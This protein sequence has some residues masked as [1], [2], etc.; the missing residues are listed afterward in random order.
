[1]PLDAA[2][3]R[4]IELVEAGDADD[5]LSILAAEVGEDAARR[6][7]AWL[8]RERAR[9]EKASRGQDGVPGRG[10]APGPVPVDKV[11]APVPLDEA[12]AHAIEL[13]ETGNADDALSVLA[14]AVGEDA[15]RRQI[16]WLA[17]D[18]TRREK[19][20]RGQGRAHGRGA[21]SIRQ[22]LRADRARGL[23]LL[24]AGDTE[25][26]I[27]ALSEL[28]DAG[29]PS[30]KGL[31][32]LADLLLK[33]GRTDEGIRVLTQLAEADPSDPA[34]WRELTRVLSAEKREEDEITVLRRRIDLGFGDNATHLRIARLLERRGR[35]R[36]AAAHREAAA[37]V[38]HDAAAAAVRSRRTSETVEDV[39]R[40]LAG[41]EAA[42]AAGDDTASVRRRLYL[43]NY[44]L[45]RASAAIMHLRAWIA[46]VIAKGGQVD[47]GDWRRVEVLLSGVGDA[48]GEIEVLRLRLQAGDDGAELH[49]RL[50]RLLH[51]LGRSEE[52]SASWAALSAR[53]AEDE[54][55][56]RRLERLRA[57]L[58]A[59]PG[60]ASKI[61]RAPAAPA[62]GRIGGRTLVFPHAYKTAGT[63]LS[64]GLDRIFAPNFTRLGLTHGAEKLAGLGREDRASLDVVAGHFT[65]D[66]AEQRLVPLLPKAPVYIGTVRDPVARAKSIYA[67]FRETYSDPLDLAQRLRVPY[68]AD[69]EVVVERW[70]GGEDWN[71]W[72][73]DQCRV[74]CGEASAERAIAAIEAH[75][76]FVLT[77]Q[78]INPLLERLAALRNIPWT[79]PL[80]VRRSKSGEFAIRPAL[81][82]R[83]R[84]WH[85][86]DR[87]LVD[88]VA[89][90]EDRM[91]ARA[92]ERLEAWLVTEAKDGN[93]MTPGTT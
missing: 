47:I 57:V 88:W 12:A 48:E 1:V 52:A 15:A 81:E 14:A 65:F 49:D 80:H 37:A 32:R 93:H 7:I 79:K 36:E 6:Q 72:R 56:A 35:D 26:A 85:E 54:A 29:E 86:E 53:A 64:R 89:A 43:A 78:G 50:V 73:G 8:A 34:G 31:G 40:E 16:A 18:H 66:D 83:L 9:R 84:D 39:Q 61:P 74:I 20:S 27:A 55:A 28:L 46:G 63:S 17:S 4:A 13:L 62:A 10:V 59:A 5:A 25:G 70:I 41:L 68:D 3:A 21:K 51:R 19:A 42:L 33:S 24:E 38:S 92:L 60:E 45:R 22:R 76:L 44:Q 90:N 67:F 30:A 82:S 71:G 58:P 11:A 75:Y 91:T 69:I 77:P 23:E 2:A 87:K